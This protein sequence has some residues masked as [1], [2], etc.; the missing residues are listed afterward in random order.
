M[1]QHIL[2]GG[3][4]RSFVKVILQALYYREEDN[5]NEQGLIII[6]RHGAHE[7]LI[8]QRA[9]DF[10]KERNSLANTRVAGVEQEFNNNYRAWLSIS[11][12]QSRRTFIDRTRFV[13]AL[14]QR[15]ASNRV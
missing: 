11:A 4:S 3:R 7:G 12:E 15:R 6:T 14:F 5:E 13:G 10:P 2:S 9:L 8:G 1:K